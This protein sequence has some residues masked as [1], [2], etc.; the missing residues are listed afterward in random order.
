MMPDPW[1]ERN[2]KRFDFRGRGWAV[3]RV[4]A[5]AAVLLTPWEYGAFRAEMRVFRGLPAPK[6]SSK[7][8]LTLGKRPDTFTPFD[9][10]GRHVA[11]G[12]TDE[13]CG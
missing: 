10:R 4:P 9:A 6:K 12:L 5:A 11:L 8:L 1:S 3:A 13:P 2:R 7:Y